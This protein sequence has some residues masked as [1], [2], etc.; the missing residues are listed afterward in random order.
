MR[1]K[2]PQP[3]QLWFNEFN[4]KVS[5]LSKHGKNEESG[6]DM[7]CFLSKQKANPFLLIGIN[8][9]ILDTVT[10]FPPAE[11]TLDALHVICRQLLTFYRTKTREQDQITFGCGERSISTQFT[12]H[13]GKS[14]NTV[15][16]GGLEPSSASSTGNVKRE[17]DDVDENETV[18]AVGKRSK[19]GSK[20]DSL[21]DVPRIVEM[22]EEFLYQIY[23]LS[24]G[25]QGKDNERNKTE[26]DRVG[27]TVSRIND[28]TRMAVI[29]TILHEINEFAS[30]LPDFAM[31]SLCRVAILTSPHR[32]QRQKA[33]M[34]MTVKEHSPQTV[35]VNMEKITE[36]DAETDQCPS[37]TLQTTIESQAPDLDTESNQEALSPPIAPSVRSKFKRRMS[38]IAHQNLPVHSKKIESSAFVYPRMQGLTESFVLELLF[39]LRSYKIDVKSEYTRLALTSIENRATM[40]LWSKALLVI[41][42]IRKLVELQ[43]TTKDQ[44]HSEGIKTSSSP[45]RRSSQSFQFSSLNPQQ[46]SLAS[47]YCSLWTELVDKK[48]QTD[49]ATQE[50]SF[51]V[52]S[53]LVQVARDK[54]MRSIVTNANFQTTKPPD[55]IPL[56]T[57]T[58]K[59]KS[60]RMKRS[61]SMDNPFTQL[62]TNIDRA[63]AWNG[64]IQNLKIDEDISP[65]WTSSKGWLK[66]AFNSKKANLNN[67]EVLNYVT[68]SLSSFN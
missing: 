25:R 46:I 43:S 28:Q 66:K 49:N 57:E 67:K 62:G 52:N 59:G 58:G 64:G 32:D 60:D 37:K 27:Q 7:Q 44:L 22:L 31:R 4:S 2:I 11:G 53:K 41:N 33:T 47:A 51:A 3:I 68:F 50:N 23:A 65:A 16:S 34:E 9:L 35:G 36:D 14:G 19:S 42:A 61:S 21:G 39:S 17:L 6:V 24:V 1:M 48:D 26:A 54:F 45:V 15:Q 18:L 13:R 20:Q 12:V 55:D 10:V 29:T 38:K 5:I 56:H 30:E 40:E 63:E 8:T